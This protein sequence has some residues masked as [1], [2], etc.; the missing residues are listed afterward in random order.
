VHRK[1]TAHTELTQ[2]FKTLIKTK[3]SSDL[4][5]LQTLGK[6]PNEYENWR[7]V[8]IHCS[9][10]SCSRSWGGGWPG[11]GVRCVELIGFTSYHS[12][13][14]SNSRI[15]VP[16]LVTEWLDLLLSSLQTGAHLHSNVPVIH[17]QHPGNTCLN[18]MSNP[19]FT[20]KSS[21][22]RMHD[23]G[24]IVPHIR[25]KVLTDDQTS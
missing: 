18:P 13:V 25:P 12:L 15:R 20:L 11:V 24:S 23:P 17:H 5:L 4:N 14:H 10:I 2:T 1:P 3:R 16:K 9:L 6:A 19:T 8:A 21:T 7:G 22:H